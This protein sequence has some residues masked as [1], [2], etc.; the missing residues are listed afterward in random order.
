MYRLIAVQLGALALAATAAVVA[1]EPARYW[2]LLRDDTQVSAAEFQ[3]GRWWDDGATLGGRRLFDRANPVRMLCDLRLGSVQPDNYILLANGDVLPGRALQFL[4]AAPEEGLPPRLL[5]ALD[6]PLHTTDPAGMTVR[7]DRVARIVAAPTETPARE[8]GTL[9]F[10]DG[11]KLPVT[12]V[13]WTERGIKALGESGVIAAQFD[14]LADLHLPK[15]DAAA[16][17]DD[18]RFY[19]PLDPQGLVGRLEAADGAVLTYRRELSRVALALAKGKPKSRVVPRKGWSEPIEYL[20]VQPSWALSP[21][22]VPVETICRQSFRARNELPLSLLPAE[23]LK[24]QSG[25]HDWSWRRNRNVRGDVLRSGRVAADLGVGTHSACEIAFDLPPG[26]KEFTA[27][28]GLDAGVGEKACAAAK[29]FRDKAGGKVL[30]AGDALRGDDE[31]VRVGPLD[32]SK[33]KRL[34]LVTDSAQQKRSADAYPFDI[35]DHV[36]WLLPMLTLEESAGDRAE[37][38][39][40][41]VPSW[42]TWEI[43][44]GDAARIDATPTWGERRER[45]DA[46]I[47]ATGTEPVTLRRTVTLIP[48]VNDVLEVILDPAEAETAGRIGLTA[49]GQRLDPA[50]VQY[51]TEKYRQEHSSSRSKPPIPKDLGGAILHWD[52]R[53]YRG[54]SVQLALGIAPESKDRPAAGLVWRRCALRGAISGLPPEGRPPLPDVPLT[55]LKPLETTVNKDRRSP[56][57]DAMPTYSRTFRPIRFLGQRFDGGYGMI[58]GSSITFAVE[59]SYGRFVAAAGCCTYYAGPFQVLLDDKVAWE[60]YA[61]HVAMPATQVDVAIP[62]GTKKLTLRIG[63]SGH[64]AGSGAWANAGFIK[65]DVAGTPGVP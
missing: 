28:V 23:V 3:N 56:T 17:L 21:L 63:G 12:A 41:F 53:A 5:V 19:P 8:P 60:T 48:Y 65:S 40:R 27:L 38:L 50:D 33:V 13:R 11:R 64:G 29:I 43:T 22:L 31:P 52:L 62:A 45:W 39:R 51:I 25:I 1:D 15:V 35:G 2:A 6:Y 4:P 30:W 58:N 26:A 34:V 59:P 16:A 18:D 44:R 46:A 14:E 9:V 54:R 57:A 42:Q 36:N 55:S 47:R 49:D 37:L 32:V 7:A 24:Q 10:A 20:H 61:M